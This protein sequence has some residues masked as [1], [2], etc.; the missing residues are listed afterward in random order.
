M[1]KTCGTVLLKTT[2]PKA[3]EELSKKQT[4]K[5][6]DLQNGWLTLTDEELCEDAAEALAQKLSK[7]Y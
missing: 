7:K 1:S 4:E 6:Y 3:L 2:D 5:V